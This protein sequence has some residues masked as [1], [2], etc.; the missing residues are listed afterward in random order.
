MSETNEVVVPKPLT[1]S[2]LRRQ[3]RETAR[4]ARAQEVTK[5]E[6]STRIVTVFKGDM[7]TYEDS[8]PTSTKGW[9]M[10]V[11]RKRQR[12]QPSYVE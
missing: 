8:D 4:L 6:I 1:A 2:E 9:T 3:K 10:V 5:Q 11:G 12:A 7:G